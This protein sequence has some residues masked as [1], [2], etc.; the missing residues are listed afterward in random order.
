M[1]SYDARNHSFNKEEANKQN[2]HNR[3]YNAKS[4]M[5]QAED[6]AV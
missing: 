5:Q 3:I 6:V 4:V 1:L 2:E